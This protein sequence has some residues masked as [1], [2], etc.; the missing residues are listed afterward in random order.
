EMPK[1]RGQ[2]IDPRFDLTVSDAPA[3]SVFNA[4]VSGTRYSM[5][6]PPTV[7][8]TITVNLKDVTLREALDSIRE[9]YGYEYRIDG[10]RVAI[11]P[12][13]S[14]AGVSQVNYLAAQRRGLSQLRVTSNTFV[15]RAGGGTPGTPGGT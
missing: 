1:L 8:G 3:A 4:L 2:P 14:R 7:T 15:G 9:L 12:A 11:R 10:T 5:L 6:V 13:A